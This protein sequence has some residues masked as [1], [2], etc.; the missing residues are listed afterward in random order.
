MSDNGLIY[1]YLLDGQGG[2][3][4]LDWDG[5]RQWS[6]GEGLLWVHLDYSDP[7]AQAWITREAALDELV[8]EAL[9]TEETRPRATAI[10]DGLLVALRGVNLSPGSNPEDM[11]AVRLWIEEQRI[12][13]TRNRPLLSMSE[14]VGL[15][16]K[17]TGPR[18]SGEFIAELTD[19]LMA[20][21]ADTVDETEDRI[22]D[23]EESLLSGES[24]AQRNAI[25]ALRRETIG[26]RR[27]LAPQREA[28]TRLQTE[29]VSWLGADDRM[30]LREVTD[31]L[32]RYVEDLDSVRDRAAVA[33]EELANRL[34]EQMNTRMYVLSLVAAVF[35]PLGFLTGL[36]G[37][38]VGGIPGAENRWA[39]DI[40][41]V[42]L[43][44][45]TGVQVWLFKKKNWL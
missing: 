38:N 43:V 21:M 2:G 26:L 36:L 5:V 39:F 3:R 32:M 25:S 44:A 41:V 28:M 18:N 15:L 10:G 37:I 17:G 1:A 9:L 6:P 12:L 45:L 19:R 34:A 27:Y 20:R 13:S 23:L 30:H 22:A 42:M 16:E 33:Q 35:L 14:L 7:G 29:R 8:A 24:Y 11:V 4:R 31:H 40:F